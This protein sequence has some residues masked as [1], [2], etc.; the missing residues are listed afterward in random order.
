MAIREREAELAKDA[1]TRRRKFIVMAGAV[2]GSLSLI[3]G[4]AVG[5]IIGAKQ[6]NSK[7][8]TTN[9]HCFTSNVELYDAV[10]LYYDEKTRRMTLSYGPTIYEWCVE[11]VTDMSFLFYGLF[12]FNEPIGLRNA[13]MAIFRV[14][15]YPR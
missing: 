6:R 5:G 10:R 12:N 3:G 13:L 15:M 4:T 11:Q 14:G 2:F 8:P 7:E 1:A 9:K